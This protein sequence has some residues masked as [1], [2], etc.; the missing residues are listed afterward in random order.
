MWN[1]KGS[2]AGHAS[3]TKLAEGILATHLQYELLLKL[4]HSRDG[5][6]DSPLNTR[7]GMNS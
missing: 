6:I 2:F 4:I 1:E 7:P 3:V 5:K